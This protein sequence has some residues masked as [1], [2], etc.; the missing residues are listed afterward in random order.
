[1][2]A[3][4]FS[5]KITNSSPSPQTLNS[6][7]HVDL[8]LDKR[9]HSSSSSCFLQSPLSLSTLFPSSPLDLSS[10]VKANEKDAMEEKKEINVKNLHAKNGLFPPPIS[11]LKLVKAGNPYTYL[12]FNEGD[13][14]FVLE[15]IRIPNRDIFRASRENGRLKLFF[16]H[17]EEE[18]GKKEKEH[19]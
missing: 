10:Q 2:E 1:M 7:T 8:S 4:N 17:S 19:N 11:C 9:S 16:D 15:E 12:S 14:S 6:N 3:H 18:E 5:S 13:E